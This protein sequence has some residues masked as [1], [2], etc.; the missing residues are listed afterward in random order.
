V[1]VVV[2]NEY[3]KPEK[4]KQGNDGKS[5]RVLKKSIYVKYPTSNSKKIERKKGNSSKK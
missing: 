5:V 1:S 3:N 4:G 2:R